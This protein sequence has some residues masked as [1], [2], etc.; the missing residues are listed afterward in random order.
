MRVIVTGLVAT[1]PVGGVAWDYLQY[2]LGFQS[3]GCDVWY[4]EDTGQWVYDPTAQDFTADVRRNAA[5]LRDALAFLDP[6]LVDRWAVRDPMGGL[7]GL[8]RAALD[9][10]CA[11]ADL[12]LN[13]S[14]SCWLRDTYRQARVAAFIDTD[15]GY[16]QA[17][18]ATVDAGGG[19]EEMRQAVELMRRHDRFFTLGEHIGA[20]DCRI[21]SCGLSWIPTRQPIALDRWE[22]TGTPGEAFT[23]VMSWKIEPPPPVVDGQR[24]GGKDVEFEKILSLPSRT[25]RPLEVAVSGQAPRD[26]LTAAGW[27]VTD[28]ASRS[29]T[30]I[31]YRDYL[32]GSRGELSIAKNA[33][34]ATRSGWFSTRT[35]AYLACGR[36]AVVQDTGWSAHVPTGPGLH[37]FDTA[38][39]AL[40][41]LAAIDGDY[42]MASRHAREIATSHFD[43]RT[44]CSRLLAD[45]GV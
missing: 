6:A 15:P 16:N 19:D 40:A 10:V 31:A 12:F 36:P 39:E 9:R 13:V 44:V 14:G 24:Y 35:A 25:T 33:Y 26:R 11:G 3:L 23:T 28:G 5:Y 29:A 41:G 4:L 45:A 27:R 1:Y 22:T 38:E 17:K 37:T 7:H 43:A 42:A 34:V 2:V 20:A 18:I 30:M 32:S 21:P 8:D